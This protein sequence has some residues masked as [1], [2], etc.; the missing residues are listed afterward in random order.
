MPAAASANASLDDDVN[1]SAPDAASHAMNVA[2][3]QARAMP[4][5]TRARKGATSRWW[6]RPSYSCDQG[7]DLTSAL[8]VIGGGLAGSTVLEHKRQ[9]FLDGSFAPGFR[10]ALHAKDLGIVQNARPPS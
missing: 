8:Q 3:T 10:L 4:A 1:S 5:T 7:A 6:P 2:R 9:A